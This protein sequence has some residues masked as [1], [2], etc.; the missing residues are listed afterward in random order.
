MKKLCVLCVLCGGCAVLHPK[1]EII[2]KTDT[3]TITK[4]VPPPLPAGDSVEVCL[5][6]GYPARVRISAKGDTLIGEQ[7][8]PLSSLKPVLAFA[9][10]YAAGASWFTTSDTVRFDRRLYGK[11]GAPRTR[12]CDELKLVGSYQGV[13]VF[14]EVTAPQLLPAILLPIRPGQFQL[15]TTSAVPRSARSRR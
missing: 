11:A 10:S 6:T 4:E 1:P 15:Y 3:V 13:P 12:A 2:T 8:V 7:R 5:S 9:G 14:A